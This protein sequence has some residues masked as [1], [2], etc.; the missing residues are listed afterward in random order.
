VGRLYRRLQN[1]Q[2]AIFDPI[3]G[4]GPRC[5]RFVRDHFEGNRV[6]KRRK[7]FGNRSSIGHL[8]KS[9]LGRPIL[10]ID[11]AQYGRR[12]TKTEWKAPGTQGAAWTAQ[13][14]VNTR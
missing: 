2:L 11:F 8:P 10:G 6:A 4:A 5:E 1:F 14:G 7:A 3:L 13:A 9:V 12:G